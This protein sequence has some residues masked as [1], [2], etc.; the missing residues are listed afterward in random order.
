MFLVISIALYIQQLIICRL[1]DN[2][3]NR[4]H[5]KHIFVVE[6]IVSSIPEKEM[7]I[8]QCLNHSHNIDHT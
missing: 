7:Q 4:V 3:I 8:S 6:S 5:L 1:R 2:T